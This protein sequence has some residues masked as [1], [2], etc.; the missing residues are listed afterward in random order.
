MMTMIDNKKV[1]ALLKNAS[2]F[3]FKNPAG[4]GKTVQKIPK[5]RKSNKIRHL[6]KMQNA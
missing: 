3:F 2:R 6:A 1:S 5:N 4:G